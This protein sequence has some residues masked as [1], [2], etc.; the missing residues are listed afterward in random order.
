MHVYCRLSAL[1]MTME[2]DWMH[3]SSPFLLSGWTDSRRPVALTECVYTER[4]QLPI[5]CPLR[6]WGR[7]CLLSLHTFHLTRFTTSMKQVCDV[8]VAFAVS[9]AFTNVSSYDHVNLVRVFFITGCC[10][11]FGD[12]N[13]APITEYV[14]DSTSPCIYLLLLVRLLLLLSVLL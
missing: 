6:L 11:C 2:L 8:Y 3:W 7:S 12:F 14:D 4:G 1:P 5:Y 10:W 13:N 9:A